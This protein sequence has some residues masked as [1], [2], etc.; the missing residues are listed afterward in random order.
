MSVP[1]HSDSVLGLTQTPEPSFLL[2]APTARPET[3]PIRD[4][5]AH[6]PPKPGPLPG[7]GLRQGLSQNKLA[8]AAARR[9]TWT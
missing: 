5:D 4:A 6:F 7:R 3:C 2:L 9:L 1:H 8:G